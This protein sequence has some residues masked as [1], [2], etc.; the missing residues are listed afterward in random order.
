MHGG[1][2]STMDESMHEVRSIDQLA[3]QSGLDPSFTQ[4]SVAS[5]VHSASIQKDFGG[6]SSEFE[7]VD[8]ATAVKV[9]NRTC[10]DVHGTDSG[11]ETQ[12]EVCTWLD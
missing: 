4:T 1:P 5:G 12:S 2:E 7:L 10:N 9:A 8:A 6:G 3:A 11:I